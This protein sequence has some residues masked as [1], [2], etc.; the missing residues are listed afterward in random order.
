MEQDDPEKARLH[1]AIQWSR[2]LRTDRSGLL[3]NARV[4]LEHTYATK[5]EHQRVLDLLMFRSRKPTGRP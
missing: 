3:R 1:A 5:Y 4:Q 2:S